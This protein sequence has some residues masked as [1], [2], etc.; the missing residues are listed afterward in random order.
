M[1]LGLYLVSQEKIKIVR[2]I[3]IWFMF[4]LGIW[5][6]VVDGEIGLNAFY[7]VIAQVFSFMLLTRRRITV[8]L[9]I[10]APLAVD[11]FVNWGPM[12][13][14]L[15]ALKYLGFSVGLS[16]LLLVY[17]QNLEL[18]RLERK[19]ADEAEKVHRAGTSV[20]STLDLRETIAQIL[21]QL[22]NIIP[23]DS[24]CVLLLEDDNYLE[25]VG[26]RGWEN[27]EDVI[28]I[29]FPVPGNNP[30]TVVIETG[31]PLILG[32][33]PEHFP[34]FHKEPH[35]HILSWL[36]IPLI[37][38]GNIMGMMAIDSMEPEHFLEE[39]IRILS[40]FADYVSIA[41]ENALLYRV[42]HQAVN[43]RAIL[44]QASQDVIKASADLEEIYNAIYTA[45]NRLMPCDAFAISLVRDD[46]YEGVFL[47][48]AGTRMENLVMPLGTGLS[49]EVIATGK[50][51][52]MERVEHE[53]TSS[54]H[55][56]G[57][58]G[59]VQSLVAVPLKMGDEIMGMMTAQSY[60]VSMYSE[61]DL[62][63]LEML[64][65]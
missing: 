59:Q 37:R 64:G 40:S 15:S 5:H 28:G 39:H 38:D 6:V 33:A 30:N 16:F 32:N 57:E 35:N 31:K 49:G 2:Y 7:F 11:L 55:K 34:E 42:T 14:F 12:Y 20:L 9:T 8:I 53:D 47:I 19:F 36:G 18:F 24:A 25:I 56:F 22:T 41:I 46:V 17:H 58:D 50:S 4:L 23:H 29:R 45:A 3:L 51:I 26:G 48:D 54:Y 1:L 13:D 60:N 27:P 10:L 63:L 44:H 61:E 65:A 43:R 52:L 62:N 21:E